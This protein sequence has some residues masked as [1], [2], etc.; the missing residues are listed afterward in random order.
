MPLMRTIARRIQ[1]RFGE[2][3]SN[4]E[5][6]RSSALYIDRERTVSK[7]QLKN[8]IMIYD[9]YSYF[10]PNHTRMNDLK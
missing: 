1:R 6:R 9:L 4:G 3:G 7:W 5:G 8:A 2:M 10:F